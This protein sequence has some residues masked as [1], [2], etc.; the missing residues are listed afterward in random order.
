MTPL[1]MVVTLVGAILLW[2]LPKR[3]A[4]VAFFALAL[5]VTGAQIELGINLTIL[6]ILSMVGVMRVVAKRENIIGGLQKMDWLVLAWGAV[7]VVSS[8]FHNK[9]G[10]TLIYRLGIAFDHLSLYFLMRVFVD[11]IEGFRWV[12]KATLILLVP[13]AFLMVVEK[14]TGHNSFAVLG[15][16]SDVSAS[17]HGKIRAQGPFAHAILGGTVGAVCLPL[18]LVF[19]R[20]SRKIALIGGAAALGVVYA[21]GSSGPIM[22][23]LTLMMALGVWKIKSQ[24]KT[25]RWTAVGVIIAL[26][27]VM[28]DPVY[29]LI[30]RIDITGGSTGW[31]RA[32]LIHA[33]I[34]HIG[35]WWVGGTD[36]T[37]HWMPT[38]VE[39]NT[40][41]T[42]ITNHF[43]KMGVWGGLLLVVLFTAILVMGF[44]YVGKLLRSGK[45][46]R[47]EKFIAWILG[48]ILFGH[49][50]TFVSVSYYDQSLA[51]LYFNLASICSI[52]AA[53]NRRKVA[54]QSVEIKKP[55]DVNDVTDVPETKPGT[56]Q[57]TPAYA[58]NFNYNS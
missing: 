38:G 16:V 15:G 8:V 47:E 17:R 21:S 33:S 29:Y 45:L 58:G 40:S 20:K 14:T 42:D 32:E 54:A 51:F 1:A 23:A 11:G 46:T 19:W 4:A 57:G 41:H 53:V 49:T 24:L 31:H 10:P 26:S 22:T 37:R 28:Q 18:A 5:Y 2:V 13:L 27:I 44:T 6:R 34:T 7:L 12:S 36:Y 48:A 52:L 30:A 39:W 56:A 43:I 55:T 9:V 3:K 50:T 35:E 25:L